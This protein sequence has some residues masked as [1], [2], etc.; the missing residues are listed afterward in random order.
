MYI[1]ITAG[2]FNFLK[3]IELKY[4]IE[5]MVIMV[6][7]NGALLLHETDGASVFKEPRKYEVI[8]SVREWQKEG[9]VVMN[10]IPVTDEGRPIFEHQFKNRAGKVANE[11]GFI[12]IKV[13][14][15]LSSNTYVI[16]T[17]WENEMSYQK[18]QSSSSYLDAHK[19]NGADKG[20]DF[21]QNFFASA[22]YVSKY[23]IM[24]LDN[25]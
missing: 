23:T 7:Q 13:L 16:L 6:N 18:W 4:P 15:P 5:T 3:S 21:Q 2:T 22:S 9:F 12:A 24:E 10:N 19:K 14:R 17:V 1:Y 25:E 8:D 11:P 20:I